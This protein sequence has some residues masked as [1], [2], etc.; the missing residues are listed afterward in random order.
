MRQIRLRHIAATGCFNKSPR[1]T[2]ENN[3][4]C[5]RILSLQSVARIQ[6]GLNSCDISRRQSKRKALSQQQCRRSDL[7]PRFVASCVSAFTQSGLMVS[8]LDSGAS[9]R[10]R[11]LA[12]DIALCS[13]ARHFT[14]T[15]P[16]FTQVYKWV[17]ANCRGNLTNCGGV[18][19]DGLA[20]CPGEVEILLNLAA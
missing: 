1:V 9:G 13:W 16:L 4:R 6:T 17:P 11:A 5:D 20:S 8:E 18:T 19:C 12:G 7:S 10:V 14:L 3:C 15:M 2:C